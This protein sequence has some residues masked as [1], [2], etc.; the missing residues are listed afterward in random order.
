MTTPRPGRVRITKTA[1]IVL[2]SYRVAAALV[3]AYPAARSLGALGAASLPDGDLALFQP[4][5]MFLLET[6]RLGARTLSA[7]AESATVV[8][9]AFATI[10]LLPLAAALADMVAPGSTRAERWGLAATRAPTLLFLRGA[11]FLVQVVVAVGTRIL[12]VAAASL[13]ES[14]PDERVT[15]LVPLAVG[16][17]GLVAVFVVGVT[18]DVARA[19]VVRL[20]AS[21]VEAARDACEAVIRAPASVLPGF[22]GPALGSAFVIAAVAWLAGLIDV[23]RPGSLRIAGVFA[24]HQVAVVAIV[25]LRLRALG[26]ALALASPAIGP[27]D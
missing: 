22:L 3:I 19:R 10:G 6:L 25:A 2:S 23:S 11:T 21:G 7:S 16:L 14:F 18:E 27:P 9:I 15:D 26:V 8:A 1:L 5:G 4:G 17:A 20:G 13:T 24:A 12:M